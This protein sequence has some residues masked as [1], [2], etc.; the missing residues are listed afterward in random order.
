MKNGEVRLAKVPSTPDNQGFCVMD[1]LA[2]AGCDLAAL[3]L[4]VH[5]TTAT[6]NAVLE[7]K[8]SRTGLITTQG[9]RDVLELGH[10]SRPQAYGMT[11]RFEPI[12]SRNLRCEVPERRDATGEVLSNIWPNNVHVTLGYGILQEARECQRGVT[13]AVN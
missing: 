9:F 5:G 13:A 8:L 7:R 12:T 1:A 11:G 6:T 3:D 2:T 10:R 4:I